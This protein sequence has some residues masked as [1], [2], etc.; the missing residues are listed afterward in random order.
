MTNIKD[1]RNS[2]ENTFCTS[3]DVSQIIIN[4][5]K[6]IWSNKNGMNSVKKELKLIFDNNENQFR[7]LQKYFL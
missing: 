6:F 3:K 4:S 1:P 5:Q 7:E 2:D